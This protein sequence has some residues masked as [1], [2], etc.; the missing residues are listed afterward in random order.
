MGNIFDGLAC[1]YDRGMWFLEALLLR[2][3]RQSLYPH[4]TGRVLELGVGT[5]ANLPL[6]APG[7]TLVAMDLSEEML[8]RARGRPTRARVYWVQADALRLPL[9]SESFDY[10]VTS[11]VLCSVA[12]P[13]AT[14]GEVRRVLRPGGWLAMVE[15]VRGEDG[16]M[17][18]LTDV[19]ERPWHRLSRSCH[20]NRETARLVADAGLRLVCTTRHGLG[21]FQ[22]ILARKDRR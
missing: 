15:H 8:R 10:V 13:V 22:I 5:G 14:L 1:G 2:G 17:R 12:D 21:L 3:L 16:W 19:L 7:V 9:R 6:Y 4:L 11:L 20:L 18:W